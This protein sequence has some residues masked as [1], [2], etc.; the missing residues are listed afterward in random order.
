MPAFNEAASIADV[1]GQV[2]DALPSAGV[3]VVDD[4]STDATAAVARASGEQVVSLA[5]NVGVGGAMR[6]GFL[7]AVRNGY[8]GVVQVDADGQH[9]P[10]QVP[11]L[12]EALDRAD[13]V[14]G[15]RFAGAG[16]Y[17]VSLPRRGAMRLVASLVSWLTGTRLTDVTSGFRATGPR[18]LEL[19][20]RAYPSEY[21]GDTLESLVLADRAGLVLTQV[22]VS[23]RP[24]SA[25]RPSHAPTR[26]AVYLGRALLV[27]A[28]ARVRVWP[29]AAGDAW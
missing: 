23:M 18:A 9:D 25:G 16:E 12:V 13:V 1:L 4:G 15:A 7:F 3:L 10:A 28:L 5:F 19:F 21:L 8:D 27:L 26:A 11:A 22:P 20:A 6:T 2:R 14:V 17:P 24:R 29:T